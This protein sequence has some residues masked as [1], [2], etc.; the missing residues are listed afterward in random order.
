MYSYKL[1]TTRTPQYTVLIVMF[2]LC[3]LLCYL[4]LSENDNSSIYTAVCYVVLVH[5]FYIQS[6]LKIGLNTGII[7][8]GN[9][10][11]GHPRASASFFLPGVRAFDLNFA[12]TDRY[13]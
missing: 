3:L 6:R 1:H 9:Y 2:M 11:P 12:G 10:A 7:L 5:V 4:V 8:T 13:M